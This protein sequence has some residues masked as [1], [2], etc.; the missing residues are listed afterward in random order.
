MLQQ[1]NSLPDNLTDHITYFD[2]IPEHIEVDFNNPIHIAPEDTLLRK[3]PR[4][5]WD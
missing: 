1:L 3:V 5:T 2:S 4:P